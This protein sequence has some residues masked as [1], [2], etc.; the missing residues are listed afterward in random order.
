MYILIL[1]VVLLGQLSTTRP[2][3]REVGMRANRA[4]LAAVEQSEDVS[5]DYAQF[6]ES[7]FNDLQDREKLPYNITWGDVHNDPTM[8][9][10]VVD[11]FWNDLGNTFDI[12][13]D[14][15]TRALW[16]YCPGLYSS[17]SGDISKLKSPKTRNVMENRKKNL[18]AYIAR[19]SEGV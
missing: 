15:Y 14:D 17:V 3:K 16:S 13:D 12:P 11:I 2:L 5:G 9:D 18:D 8:Y 7:T 10:M 4:Y 1:M 6:E 19:I